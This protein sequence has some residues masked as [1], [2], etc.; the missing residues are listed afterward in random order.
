MAAPLMRRK[1]RYRAKT[2]AG[3]LITGGRSKS[4]GIQKQA[5]HDIAAVFDDPGLG[6]RSK[7]ACETPGAE[8]VGLVI[9]VERC[10]DNVHRGNSLSS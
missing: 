10:I 6:R 7:R 9:S 3:T 1:R 2:I 5:A 4:E 8:D